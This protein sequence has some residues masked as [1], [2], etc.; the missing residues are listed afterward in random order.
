[1]TRISDEELPSSQAEANSPDCQ[2]MTRLSGCPQ[3][4]GVGRAEY[5]HLK[6]YAK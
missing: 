1:M 6:G 3:V 4:N 5:T 2:G